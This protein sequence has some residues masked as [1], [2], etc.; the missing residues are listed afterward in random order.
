MGLKKDYF[1]IHTLQS[2]PG[3]WGCTCCNPF[4]CSSRKMKPK[5]R[6][7]VRRVNKYRLRVELKTLD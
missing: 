7:I 1:D 4:D 2:G 5:A 6:R 3:G